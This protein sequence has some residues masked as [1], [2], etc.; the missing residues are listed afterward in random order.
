MYWV[1]SIIYSKSLTRDVVTQIIQARG[2]II[3][4]MTILYVL[5]VDF[6]EGGKPEYPEKNPRSTREIN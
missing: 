2:S 6:R 3:K 5:Y 4:C 1:L